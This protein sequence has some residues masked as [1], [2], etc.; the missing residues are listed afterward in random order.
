LQ[1]ESTIDSQFRKIGKFARIQS[2]RLAE[3]PA[4][5]KFPDH[6]LGATFLSEFRGPRNIQIHGL[7]DK[8]GNTI[9]TASWYF[10]R[11]DLLGRVE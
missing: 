7:P 6:S 5:S 10:L 11:P 8:R 9:Q 3:C 1:E 2:R 4:V